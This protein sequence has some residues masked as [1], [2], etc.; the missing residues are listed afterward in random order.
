MMKDKDS[1]VEFW[2]RVTEDYKKIIMISKS[3]LL[4]Y[5]DDEREK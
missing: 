3:V 4:K 5:S 1:E 2:K